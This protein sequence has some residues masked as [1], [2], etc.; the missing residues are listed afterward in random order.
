MKNN[1]IICGKRYNVC[2]TCEENK[3]IYF[4]WRTICDTAECYQAYVAITG[5]RDKVM[6]KDKAKE[7]LDSLSIT[8]YLPN[9]QGQVDEICKEN[10]ETAGDKSKSKNKRAEK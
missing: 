3:K 5:V 6:T 7:I 1:C 10:I 8:S 9:V 4:G 2:R